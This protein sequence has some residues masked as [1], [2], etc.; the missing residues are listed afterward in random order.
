MSDKLTEMWAAFEAHKP[1]R[2]YAD[3]WQ[4]MCR[5]RTEKAMRDAYYAAPAGSAAA[6][7]VAVA[8]WAAAAA[9]A[10]VAREADEAAQDAIDAIKEAKP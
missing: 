1:K 4:T 2:S 3:A 5:E 6:A 7:A 9:A 10:R 8:P